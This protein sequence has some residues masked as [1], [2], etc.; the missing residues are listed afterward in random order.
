MIESTLYRII[1][2]SFKRKDGFKTP[3][4]LKSAELRAYGY[5]L[6]YSIECMG[7]YYDGRELRDNEISWE[8]RDFYDGLRK[9]YIQ[10]K[11]L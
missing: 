1:K 3:L 11:M 10:K 4:I 8:S 7:E 2:A 5:K 9:M 6:E